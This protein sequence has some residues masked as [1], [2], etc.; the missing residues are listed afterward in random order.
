MGWVEA[1]VVEWIGELRAGV[2]GVT[3]MYSKGGER[4]V[5]S[6]PVR[7]PSS[8]H[9]VKTTS[10]FPSGLVPDGNTEVTGGPLTR[11]RTQDALSRF[12]FHV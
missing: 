5:P 9:G 3:I 4:R 10:V 1:E 6:K 12:G 7:T 2:R 8:G 11:P